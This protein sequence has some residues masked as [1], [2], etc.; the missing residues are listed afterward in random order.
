ME[1]QPAGNGHYFFG[2]DGGT[3]SRT[4]HRK[5]AVSWIFGKYGYVANSTAVQSD[6]A[7]HGTKMLISVFPAVPF[8]PALGLLFFY[9]IGKQKELQIEADLAQRR[10]A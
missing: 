6:T 4:Q 1:K 8:L 2:H 7:I 10:A 5:L 3:K 9:E